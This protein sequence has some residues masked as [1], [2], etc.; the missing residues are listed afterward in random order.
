ML[1]R[2][3]NFEVAVTWSGNLGTGTSGHRQYS[4]NHEIDAAQLPTIQGSADKTFHGDESRW[5]PELLF[6]ASISECHMMTYL[7]LAT[8]AGVRVVAYQ[9][10]AS[11]ILAMDTNG[12]GGEFSQIT[13]K[14]E[15]TIAASGTPDQSQQLAQ[16]LH[17]DV[18]QYCFIARSVKASIRHEATVLLR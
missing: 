2:A 5:N 7:Y 9:D 6:L 16:K 17:D 8:Q 11:G 1:K 10:V 15:V 14:P 18:G 3:H 4:R 13:L 12:V